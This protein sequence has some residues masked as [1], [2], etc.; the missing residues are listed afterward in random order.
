MDIGITSLHTFSMETILSREVTYKLPT[1]QREYSWTKNE[2]SQLWEDAI[3]SIKNKTG[4][5]F[6]FMTFKEETTEKYSIIEG[7]QSLTKI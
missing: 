1:F 6:G 3:A 2:W 5:F 7:Q 4:H